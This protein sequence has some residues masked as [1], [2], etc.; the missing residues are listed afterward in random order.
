MAPRLPF[1]TSHSKLSRLRTP[2]EASGPG[3]L[4]PRGKTIEKT[5]EKLITSFA[6]PEE[7]KNVKI[8]YDFIIRGLV[9][10]K[11]TGHICKVDQNRV[12]GRCY[13][14]YQMVSKI[15]DH[16]PA[17]KVEADSTTRNHFYY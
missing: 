10:D 5:I 11:K 6:Y 9:V 2:F 4:Q 3:I 16:L 13:H 14:G 12:V 7:I 8:D 17:S 15:I 1:K